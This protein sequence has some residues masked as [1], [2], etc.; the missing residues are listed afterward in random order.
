MDADSGCF[1]LN[2][3]SII[4][5]SPWDLCYGFLLNGNTQCSQI[6]AYPWSFFF[7]IHLLYN[8]FKIID[9]LFLPVDWANSSLTIYL[10]SPC[11]W[12]Q[13]CRDNYDFFRQYN[14]VSQINP[15]PWLGILLSGYWPLGLLQVP[16]K[17]ILSVLNKLFVS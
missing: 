14:M 8:L 10:F 13:N 11:L 2:I 1:L 6:L 16:S 3:K 7:H 15:Q 4:L 12:S 5:L 9:I 17:C